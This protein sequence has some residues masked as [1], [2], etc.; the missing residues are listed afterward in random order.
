M[1]DSEASSGNPLHL[2]YG[3][4]WGGLPPVSVSMRARRSS[5]A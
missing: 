4:S 1:L 5:S 3:L 2:R